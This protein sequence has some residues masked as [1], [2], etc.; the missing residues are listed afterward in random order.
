MAAALFIGTWLWFRID[1][2]HQLF[3]EEKARAA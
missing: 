1:P 2:T 3:E